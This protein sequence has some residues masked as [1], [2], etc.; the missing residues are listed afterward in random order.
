MYAPLLIFILA[1][2]AMYPKLLLWVVGG[3]VAMIAL[4]LW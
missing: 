1:V 4:R 2:V 3:F